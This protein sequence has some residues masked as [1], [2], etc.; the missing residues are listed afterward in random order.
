MILNDVS[1]DIPGAGLTAIVGPSGAGKTS[2]LYVLSGLDSP[3]SGR[4][5]IGG[6]DI[7]ALDEER[8]SRFIRGHIGFV[9][10]QYN[11]VP[12]L[13]VEENVMLPL[14]LAHRKADYVHV[15]Q[16]LSRFGLRQRART[17]VS[18]LSGGE[19]QRVALCRALLLRPSVVF[20]DEPTG[21]LD[22][23][24][25]ELVLQVLRELADS[26]SSVVM[27]THDTDAAA[28]ADRVVFL[29]DG[30]ITHVAGRL[31]AGQIVEGMRRTFEPPM[32]QH[33]QE[34]R[35]G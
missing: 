6:T 28:L 14:S 2:L 7:Y 33:G 27:V 4:V 8:R 3:D 1:L 11:L 16:L 25:S 13:T 9:F 34:V 30:G 32:S 15:T 18:A 19:Q 23:A 17:V 35:R 5:V 24:N 21:A 20:A 29:R 26:G 12:Y 22:T 31:T 10:Q